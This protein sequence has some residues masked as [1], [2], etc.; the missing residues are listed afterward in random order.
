MKKT[1]VIAEDEKP[2]AEAQ[3]LILGKEY[4]VHLAHDGETALQLIQ[5]VRPDLVVLD[6]MLPKMG[7]VDICRQIRA[8][9]E[10]RHTKVVMVTAKNT[11]QDELR[12]LGVGADDYIMKPFEPLEL[13]HVV[14]QVANR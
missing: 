8:S 3:K 2:I 14:H 12:G 9:Q 6:L 1:I 10:L 11:R 13:L 5:R 4:A 7:G